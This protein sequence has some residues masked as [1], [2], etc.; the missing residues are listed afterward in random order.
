M[1]H[2][3]SLGRLLMTSVLLSAC[4]GEIGLSRQ[5]EAGTDGS[6]GA[7]GGGGVAGGEGGDSTGVSGT[8]G[9]GGTAGSGTPAGMAGTSG[10]ASGGG[11]AVAG[12]G[13]GGAGTTGSGGRGG[14]GGGGGGT[15]G[16]GG[17]GGS[18]GGRG[19]STGGSTGGSGGGVAFNPCP[20]NG[21]P[22]KVLP[23]GDS[24]TAGTGSEPQGGGGYRVDLF[25]RA[26]MANKKLTFVGTLMNGPD[27]VASMPFPK[28]HSGYGGN[29][30]AQITAASIY[31]PSVATNPHIVLLHIGTNDLYSEA[32]GAPTRLATLVDKLTTSL[33]NSL[34][35]VAKLIPSSSTYQ[36]TMDYNAAI[37]PLMQQRTAAGKHVVL[38][39][40]YTGWPA[41]SSSDGV[42]PNVAGYKWMAGVWYGAISGVLP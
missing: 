13:G 5:G 31:D 28:Q 7:L 19:G 21:D 8:T 37:G 30:I 4:T 34:I 11:G 35:L 26:V 14:T 2:A 3:A 24:I 6:G 17:R 9:S 33:P 22:C 20:T 18:T 12:T 10:G 38:V 16:A 41:N 27:S 25:S 39:D 23:F 36:P 1:K 40:L 29:L 32:A 42:H 15:T